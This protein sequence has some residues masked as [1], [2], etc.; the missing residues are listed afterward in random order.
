MIYQCPGVSGYN[1][2]FCYSIDNMPSTEF[3][4]LVSGRHVVTVTDTLDCGYKDT[5]I[6]TRIDGPQ[7]INVTITSSGCASADGEVKIDSVTDG[8][9]PYKFALDPSSPAAATIYANLTSGSYRLTVADSAGCTLQTSVNVPQAT[10]PS[11]AAIELSA[12]HCGLQDGAIKV[13]SVTGGTAPWLYSTDSVHF[14]SQNITGLPSGNYRLFVKDDRGCVFVK[15]GLHID[16][17]A[18]P[19]NVRLNVVDALCGRENGTVNT[20][21]VEQ[22]SAPFV[23]AIDTGAYKS[24]S[25]INQVAPGTHLLSVKDSRGCGYQK[26]FSVQYRPPNQFTLI[27]YDTLVCYYQ[28]VT[29]TL[30][31][32]IDSIQ[33]IR[34]TVPRF[35]FICAPISQKMV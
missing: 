19:S 26:A 12:A 5:I 1:T 30:H 21:G 32:D 4:G 31:G 13:I 2:P 16:S 18:G 3:T 6:V 11:G 22:G 9:A 10:P 33:S 20:L 8:T 34:W 14:N 7:R 24:A 17:V 27:P 25:T 29:L 35:I 28:P 23:Y 15:T